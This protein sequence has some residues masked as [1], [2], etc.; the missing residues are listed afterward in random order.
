M[1]L[2]EFRNLLSGHEVDTFDAPLRGVAGMASVY[3]IARR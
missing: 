2:W 1:P 3:R